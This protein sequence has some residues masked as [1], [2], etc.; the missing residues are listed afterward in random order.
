MEEG[1]FDMMITQILQQGQGIENMF[2]HV[3]S[4]L[5]RKTDFY[6]QEGNIILKKNRAFKRY[7]KSCI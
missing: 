1:T 2:A 5:R 7:S 4:F 6:T 3:F